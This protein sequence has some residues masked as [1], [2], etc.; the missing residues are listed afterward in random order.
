M[1]PDDNSIIADLDAAPAPSTPPTPEPT[2]ES[3]P[4]AT[5]APSLSATD[6]PTP[7]A[8]PTSG[9]MPEPKPLS[10]IAGSGPDVTSVADTPRLVDPTTIDPT[11]P[12]AKKK[13]KLPLIIVAVIAV[14][15]LLGL[16]IWA[17]ISLIGGGDNGG[18]VADAER[19]AFF[20]ENL[21]GDGTYAVFNDKGEQLTDFVYSENFGFNA[22]GYAIV[23]KDGQ[24]A[25]LANTGK[26]SVPYGKYADI[27][28]AGAHFVVSNEGEQDQLIDGAGEI[29]LENISKYLVHDKLVIV[30]QGSTETVFLG[31][32]EKLGKVLAGVSYMNLKSDA[33]IVAMNIEKDLCIVNSET[34]EIAYR[35]KDVDGIYEVSYIQKTSDLRAFTLSKGSSGREYAVMLDGNLHDWATKSLL[36]PSITVVGDAPYAYSQDLDTRIMHIV[37]PDGSDFDAPAVIT[38]A[39]DIY[40][41]DSEHY[42]YYEDL[43]GLSNYRATIVAG[44][45]TIVYENVGWPHYAAAVKGYTIYDKAENSTLVL[46]KD[47]EILFECEGNSLYCG[48]SVVSDGKGNF[49]MGRNVYDKNYKLVLSADGTLSEFNGYYRYQNYSTN[50]YAVLNIDGEAKVELGIYRDIVVSCGGACYVGQRT[51]NDYD[52]LNADFKVVAKGYKSLVDHGGY[53]EGS[54]DSKLKYITYDGTVFYGED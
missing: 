39:N 14:V 54:I 26:L 11:K 19:T 47:G 46:S 10:E 30:A 12:E 35:V 27:R 7:S 2:P 53:V 40:P 37:T 36:G 9:F 28:S 48:D 25:V 22:A 33:I 13:S 3:A 4:E 6:T 42:L 49:I 18:A 52:L 41:I 50:S 32:G 15:A 8:E 44:D 51:E 38:K 31:N 1:N 5:P 43:P 20:L 29:V 16:G 24:F 17:I 23:E 21:A 45:K 34:G